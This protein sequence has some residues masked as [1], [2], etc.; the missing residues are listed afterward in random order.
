M[1]NQI[2]LVFDSL[3]WDIF[4]AAD[5]PFLK[6][7]GS[8][9]KALTP[10]NYTFPAHMSFFAGKLPHTFDQTDY[11]DTAAT[12]FSWLRRPFRK[13]PLWQL[14]NPESPRPARYV[15]QGKN[16]IEGFHKQGYL[17]IGTGAVNWFNPNL[18]AGEYLTAS[19][20]KFRFFTE[21]GHT[22]HQSAE[23]QIEW[24]IDCLQNTT[25]LYF[26]FI[27]FGETHHP[28]TYKNCGWENTKNPYGDTE[29]CK[30]RQKL[31][32]EYLDAQVSK[33]LNNLQFYDLV[34]CSDHG[35]AMGEDGLWGHSF[36]HD[37]VL[38]V[39]LL[40]NLSKS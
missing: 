29:E 35:E 30:H 40:I 22:S 17:T 12:R 28:F 9:K 24:A 10:G 31:C 25:N 4:E 3:R 37:K 20:D 36:S 33:L 26:L 21:Q 15:L 32:L 16:I 27:N 2:F 7:L 23:Q 34:A 18:P 14:G 38:E 6:S 39:P 13:Q 5:A 8:W 11:Y 19:F 1:N